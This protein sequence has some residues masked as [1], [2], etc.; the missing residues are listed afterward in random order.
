MASGGGG[1][2]YLGMVVAR[3]TVEEFGP[4][5]LLELGE[6][7][8]DARVAVSMGLG[9]PTVLVEKVPRGTE[10][11]FA[12]DVLEVACGY[13]FDALLPSEAGGWNSLHPMLPAARRGLPLLDGDGMGRAFPELQMVTWSVF[14]QSAAPIGVADERGNTMLIDTRDN[15]RAEDL[16]RGA[17]VAMGGNISLACY[18]MTGV[19]ARS[20]SVAGT[21]TLCEEVG[22][23]LRYARTNRV[24][25]YDRIMERLG[26]VELFCGKVRD[27]E[28]RTE[29]GFARGVA[30][31]E[32][33]DA[34]RGGVFA[35]EF[36]NEFLMARRDGVPVCTAPDLIAAFDAET[37]TPITGESLKYGCRALIVG[38][39][40]AP[41]WR[42]A[43]GLAVAGPAA[44]GYAGVPYV[45]VEQR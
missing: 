38:I 25:A 26:A 20:H 35:M 34:Y 18:G 45:P 23:L 28:R 17:T 1:D 32:G 5:E 3:R 37:L 9:A 40:C 11:E 2:P 7:P 15:K 19:Q 42:T 33:F 43:E 13:R 24:D 29:G 39:P 8:D 10:P 36:Q 22:A 16:C 4:I 30:T 27:V 31:L 21:Y 6:V 41:Q 14:G 44:F 12:L